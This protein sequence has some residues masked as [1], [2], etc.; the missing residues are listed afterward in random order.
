MIRTFARTF[1]VPYLGISALFLMMSLTP[2]ASGADIVNGNIPFAFQVGNKTMPAGD[3]E[4][5]I[6]RAKENVKIRSTEKKGPEAM[7]LIV[8]YLAKPAHGNADDTDI[9]FDKVGDKY[10]LSEVWRAGAD[11]VLVHVTKGPHEHRVHH[12]KL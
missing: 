8:T 2:A 12:F 7:E 1:G 11:G 4:I 6:D 5:E 10:I 9:V 3:Y